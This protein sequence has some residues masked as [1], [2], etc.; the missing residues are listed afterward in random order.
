VGGHQHHTCYFC[1]SWLL[2]GCSTLARIFG[3]QEWISAQLPPLLDQPLLKILDAMLSPSAPTAGSAAAT[4][5]ATRSGSGSLTL[6]GIGAAGQAVDWGAVGLAHAHGLAGAC[7]AIGLRFAG[8]CNAGAEALLR[9]HL[10]Q[11][12]HAKRRAPGGPNEQSVAPVAAAA[13]A[14]AAQSGAGVGIAVAAAA[15]AVGKLDKAVIENCISVVLLALAL[16]MAGSGHLPT[17]R[18]IQV[19]LI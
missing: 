19:R 15:A 16:V 14:A 8:T 13:A 5:A 10:L 17:F 2:L 9:H 4:A 1:V 12:L 7:F 18:L 3:L 6:G 11:L